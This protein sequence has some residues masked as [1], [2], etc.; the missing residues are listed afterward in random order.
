MT[1]INKPIALVAGIFILLAGVG[2]TYFL[3]EGDTAYYCEAENSVGICWKLSKINDVGLVTRCYYNED[4]PTKY[5]YCKSGWEVFE[6]KIIGNETDYEIEVDVD[7]GTNKEIL[8]NIGIG[9]FEVRN[10]TTGDLIGYSQPEISYYCKDYICYYHIYQKD[11]INKPLSFESK[12]CLN[13]SEPIEINEEI[14]CINWKILTDGEIEKQVLNLS[15][16]KLN[17]IAEIRKPKEDDS[18]S[19]IKKIILN[20]Q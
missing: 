15:L 8:E 18:V 14:E 12:S 16:N 17:E 13:W 19:I 6:Q 5:N 11:G 10:E 20:I 1:E 9:K 4:T 2:T 3:M 7:F